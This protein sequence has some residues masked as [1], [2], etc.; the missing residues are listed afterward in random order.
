M[1]KSKSTLLRKTTSSDYFR[2][3]NQ[4]SD[5]RAIDRILGLNPDTRRGIM[6]I[7]AGICI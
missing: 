6:T 2:V 5:E 4:A 7:V 3:N 1:R